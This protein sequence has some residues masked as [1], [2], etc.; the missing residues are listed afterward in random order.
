MR[1]ITMSPLL[2]MPYDSN[3]M[4]PVDYGQI[5]R[6]IMAQ[7]AQREEW[8]AELKKNN[9]KKKRRRRHMKGW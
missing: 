4:V 8:I 3:K 5:E 7:Q 6:Q 1:R 9:R 2:G